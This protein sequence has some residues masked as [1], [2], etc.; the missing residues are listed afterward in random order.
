MMRMI[1]FRESIDIVISVIALSLAV[2]FAVAGVGIL[3]QPARALTII[4]MFGLV[5]GL[6]FILHELSHKYVAIFFG[7]RA[8]FRMWPLGL[9]L[10]LGMSAILHVVF[11]A[12][13]AVYIEARQLTR[14]QSGL[15]SLAGPFANLVLAILFF[16][17]A[18]ILPLQ[19]AGSNIWS[20]GA[21]ANVWLGLFNMIPIHPLDGAKIKDWSTLAWLAFALIFVLAMFSL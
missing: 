13:G 14:R 3:A 8:E 17:L 11:I 12:P 7:A 10:A 21:L 15:I 16:I 19:I 2:T 9:L 6:G 20:Y 5:I 1:T 18:L 4:S